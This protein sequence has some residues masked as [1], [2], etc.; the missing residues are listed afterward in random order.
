MKCTVCCE[1]VQLPTSRRLDKDKTYEVNLLHALGEQNAGLQPAKVE[2][3]FTTLGVDY[4]LHRTAHGQLQRR[5]GQ[6]VTAMATESCEAV[7]LQESKLAQDKG[8]IVEDV[9][10]LSTTGDCAWPNRGSGRSYASFCGMFVL[11][12]ALTKRI[13]STSIFDKM[14]Y[15]CE[16]AEK[17][18]LGSDLANDKY[19][20]VI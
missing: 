20:N 8:D 17:K 15:T 2:K 5:V 3:F 1:Q 4:Q 6:A 13:L 16:Q 9:V 7:L 14:C 11:V 18:P 19:G 10:Q 12:G